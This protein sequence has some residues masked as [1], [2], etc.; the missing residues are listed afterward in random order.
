MNNLK[1]DVIRELKKD[2]NHKKNSEVLDDVKKAK[3]EKQIAM[4]LLKN[5]NLE[6]LAYCFEPA[7]LPLYWKEWATKDYL[8]AIKKEKNVKKESIEE[9]IE[10]SLDKKY[11]NLFDLDVAIRDIFGEIDEMSEKY[12]EMLDSREEIH[13]RMITVIYD[14]L[15]KKSEEYQEIVNK[16]YSFMKAD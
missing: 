15:R 7:D 16:I 13:T 8:K 4:L 9:K 6:A 14:T 2:N 3:N 11:F 1:L 12:N 5:Y 10:N